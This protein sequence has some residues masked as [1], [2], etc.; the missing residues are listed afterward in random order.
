MISTVSISVVSKAGLGH[1]SEKASGYTS[2]IFLITPWSN[3]SVSVPAT[4]NEIQVHDGT[5]T[6]VRRGYW[7]CSIEFKT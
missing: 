2:I 7:C 1:L 3:L 6:V 5:S 4:K